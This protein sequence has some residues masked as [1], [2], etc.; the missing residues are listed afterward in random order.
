M[1]S[2]T[3]ACSILLFTLHYIAYAVS[4]VE[5]NSV[6]LVIPFLVHLMAYDSLQTCFR[7]QC[8]IPI[9]KWNNRQ[10]T[11]EPLDKVSQIFCTQTL[12][13]FLQLQLSLWGQEETQVWSCLLEFHLT[14]HHNLSA[15][16]TSCRCKQINSQNFTNHF[17]SLAI[18][19]ILK[20]VKIAL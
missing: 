7:K 3:I 1:I 4:A 20:S 15:I 12:L 17:S 2:Y 9:G 19:L 13:G 14:E 11:T 6:K 5:N 10:L 18:N 8:H 16:I